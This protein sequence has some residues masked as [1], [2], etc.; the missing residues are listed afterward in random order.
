MVKPKLKL[1]LP[2]PSGQPLC[3]RQLTRLSPVAQGQ[4]GLRL[5]GLDEA[6][7]LEGVDLDPGHYCRHCLREAGLLP[8]VDGRRS[9]PA[10]L[11][12][13]TVEEL[14]AELTEGAE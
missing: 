14:Y 2:G 8:P 6:G 4:R 13:L 10:D 5:A 11:D 7:G 1:H 3:Q 9:S 12:E